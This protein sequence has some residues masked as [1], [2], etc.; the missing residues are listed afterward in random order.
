MP[1]E[2]GKKIIFL[3]IFFI[4]LLILFLDQISKSLV[5]KTLLLHQSIP[6]IK[7]IFHIT[8]IHNRGAAFGI[9]KNYA[10]LFIVIS[11]ASIILI[12]LTLLS[13]QRH[14]IT[15]LYTISLGLIL[16]GA[17]GNLIDRIFLG[18]VIDFLDFRIWPVFN[19]ADSAISVGAV[20]LGWC[21]LFSKQRKV[22]C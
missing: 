1:S 5:V 22:Y 8:L 16:A 7:G 9:L 10:Y 14:K 11:I 2:K 18:Y 20:L 3:M 6:V 19:V 13:R 15:S 17:A 4:V 21:V 12:S